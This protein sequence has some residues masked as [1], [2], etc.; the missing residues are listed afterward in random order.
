MLDSLHCW[1]DWQFRS[2][3]HC[4]LKSRPRQQEEVLDLLYS[5]RKV[6]S[7]HPQIIPWL[8]SAFI[9]SHNKWCFLLRAS[10]L[11]LT[12]RGWGEHSRWAFFSSLV[13]TQL[14]KYHPPRAW[15]YLGIPVRDHEFV[16]PKIDEPTDR[17]LELQSD[18]NPIP[19]LRYKL[20]S[21]ITEVWY[22]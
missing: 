1:P 17:I 9:W 5:V 16:R 11:H 13:S 4:Q 2:D 20:M 7:W 8:S 12:G 22:Y 21:L 15:T 6:H 14:R 19:I 3:G 18:L 10:P